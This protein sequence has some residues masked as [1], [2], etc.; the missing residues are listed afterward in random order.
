MSVILHARLRGRLLVAT[1]V[2]TLT[3]VF[4]LFSATSTFAAAHIVQISSDPFTNADSQHKT[5][6][7]PDTF[8]FGNTIVSAFQ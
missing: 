3:L 5:E 8:A 4:S 6:V 7:E 1:L 2:A